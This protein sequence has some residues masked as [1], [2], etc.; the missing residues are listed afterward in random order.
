MLLPARAGHVAAESG[1]PLIEVGQDRLG[2]LSS[3]EAYLFHF[4]MKPTPEDGAQIAGGVGNMDSP[5]GGKK[6]EDL[7]LMYLWLGREAGA[8][9]R[10]AARAQVRGVRGLGLAELV[11][12]LA[13]SAVE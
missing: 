6:E 1:A 8:E 3:T 9:A 7:H 13:E 2:V 4:Q 5:K 10:T 12:R 11:V